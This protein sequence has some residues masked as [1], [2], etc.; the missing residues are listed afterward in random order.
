MKLQIPTTLPVFTEQIIIVPI[1]LPSLQNVFEIQGFRC[2]VKSNISNREL[3]AQDFPIDWELID[4][5]KLPQITAYFPLNF[6]PEVGLYYK[7]Q[8]AA[9][10]ASGI[11]QLSEVGMA[12]Y[13]A[14]P[15]LILT[16]NSSGAIQFSTV[17]Y[18]AQYI[19]EDF[20]EPLAYYEFYLLKGET[21]L[22]ESGRQVYNNELS[23]RDVSHLIANFSWNYNIVLE[24]DQK[25]QVKCIAY[26]KGGYKISAESEF[27]LSS[28]VN[29]EYPFA[30]SAQMVY[31]EGYVSIKA[32]K[33]LEPV[34][35]SFVLT[36]Q[37]EEEIVELKRFD[38]LV[39]DCEIYRDFTVE[40]GKTYD[41]YLQAYN[42]YGLRA[43]PL[44]AQEG[45]LY[46][47]FED[48]FLYDGERQLKLKYNPAISSF[49]TTLQETKTDTIGSKYPV[50][51]R[52]EKLGYK[53]FP[54]SSLLSHL[55]DEQLLFQ[56]GKDYTY[57][58][59]IPQRGD[60]AAAILP[61]S[62][63]LVSVNI[64]SERKFRLDVLDWLNNGEPKLFRSP[65]EGNYI[66][67][68][69]NVSLSPNTTLGR[70]LYTMSC[71]AY[72]VS[73]VN[74]SSLVALGLVEDPKS[75][76]GI[77]ME[78]S[79]GQV[80]L[81]TGQL[82][83]I[84]N[85]YFIVHDVS[86]G[87]TLTLVFDD[88]TTTS[89]T[90]G[91]SNTY[92]YQGD[93]VVVGIVSFSEGGYV[94]IIEQGLKPLAVKS[95]V[96]DVQSS[97]Q[98]AQ[99]VGPKNIISELTDVKRSIGTIYSLSIT[100]IDGGG[101]LTLNDKTIYYDQESTIKAIINLVGVTKLSITE[102]L[103]IDMAY[104]QQEK[105]YIY[106]DIQYGEAEVIEAKMIYEANPSEATY[107]AYIEAL[108]EAIKND[109]SNHI[110]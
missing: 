38:C 64:A 14:K 108:S 13:V 10:T 20:S 57:N 25:Y 29:V 36:R 96:I 19:T 46:A 82:T 16:N 104:E 12:K 52:N 28:A 99:F 1:T 68:L 109:T 98:V 50:F 100:P 18:S 8:V 77:V 21:I 89:I 88:Y 60:A 53:E 39:A 85:N 84:D 49:K 91:A 101:S 2:I 92:R 44:G 22:A 33:V 31:D 74:Y 45:S 27:R 24:A 93:K 59:I 90:I 110:L 62:T 69:M 40:Q 94:D 71:T 15:S 42:S 76:L 32:V 65:T 47:D 102:G 6:T 73:D 9:I 80:N 5:E 4:E 86:R 105:T 17:S 79:V 23:T 97:V 54:I 37:C 107:Q 35:S 106:E 58:P 67:R 11:S 43:V 41:Y 87:T 70:M 78:V 75:S 72:E 7:V 66:V 26:S 83:P 55:A 63:N 34:E 95:S 30:L 56:K 61:L 103:Q 51:F 81:I 48:I 3:M